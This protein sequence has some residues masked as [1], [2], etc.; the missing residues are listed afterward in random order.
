MCHEGVGGSRRIAPLI[1]NL[2]NNW[3][4]TVELKRLPLYLRVIE[5]PAIHW[6]GGWMDLRSDLAIWENRKFLGL[7]DNWKWFVCCPSRSPVTVINYSSYLSAL[8]FAFLAK[9]YWVTQIRKNE[10]GVACST[11]GLEERYTEEFGGETWG[12]E[13]AWK[14]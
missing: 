4:W 3:K 2:G 13:A 5:T 8:W 11:H 14:I 7:I 9:Y 12:R 6:V 1:P 10:M